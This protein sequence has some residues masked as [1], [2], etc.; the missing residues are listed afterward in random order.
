MHGRNHDRRSRH[1]ALEQFVQFATV[2]PNATA[3]WAIVDLDT[4]ALGHDEGDVAAGGT[5]HVGAFEFGQAK[6][7][8]QAA[9]DGA[10]TFFLSA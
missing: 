6:R 9:L 1:S 8:P 3:A 10:T 4:L 2:Q 7:C 5:F